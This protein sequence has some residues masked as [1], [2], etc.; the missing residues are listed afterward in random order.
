MCGISGIVHADGRPIEQT[1]LRN[2]VAIIGHRGPDEVG[3]WTS[4][5]A[6]FGHDR[7]SI[8]DIA[9]GQQPMSNHDNSL[10]ITFNGEIFNYLE[11]T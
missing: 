6:G 5:Q 3:V 1:L 7:L 4:Q 10:W 2:M 9:C 11:L 8:I